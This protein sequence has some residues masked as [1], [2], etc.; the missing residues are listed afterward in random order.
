MSNII[1]DIDDDEKEVINFY[2]HLENNTIE[3]KVYLLDIKINIEN[4]INKM[5]TYKYDKDNYEIIILDMSKVDKSWSI[6]KH[7]IP[8]FKDIKYN[9]VKR[10][11]IN[12]KKYLI[13]IDNNNIL[14]E[15]LNNFSPPEL[16]IEKNKHIEFIGGRNRFSNLRE[17]EVKCMPFLIDK[18]QIDLFKDFI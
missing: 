17:M 5:K 1:F 3:N 4:I 2:D 6:S 14:L 10:R 12:M 11:F 7:Y 15:D 9:N 8:Y 18:E 16:Y 13:D